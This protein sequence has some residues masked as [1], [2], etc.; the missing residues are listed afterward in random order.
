MRLHVAL[1]PIALSASI[2][3]ACGD[4]SDKADT[5][6]QVHGDRVFDAQ[7][8]NAAQP[9]AEVQTGAVSATDALPTEGVA[10]DLEG[11]ETDG[12]ETDGVAGIEPG[13][14]EPFRGPC[15]VRWT[16]G[17]VL[18]F[19][20]TDAGGKVRVDE[21]GDGKADVCGT[22]ETADG[23]TRKIGIDEGCDRKVDLEIVPAYDPKANVATASYTGSAGGKQQER[24]VTLVT[25]PSFTGLKPGYVL[26]APRSAAKLRVTKGLVRSAKVTA[27]GE[28]PPL[29]ATFTYDDQGRVKRIKEDFES[30]GSVDRRFD[31]T[32]D[33]LGNVTR[34]SAVVGSGEAEQKGTARLD[35]RCWK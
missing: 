6:P 32:Y 23:R 14:A 12:G 2:S 28:G 16:T 11:W 33:A 8:P 27:P 29:S 9:L 15:T 10:E 22:F 34:M 25:M 13:A 5:A 35:Y 3:I 26:H 30:D 19:E 24:D 18:R 1:F 4:S 21:D 7:D 17:A 20:Y 31:Y